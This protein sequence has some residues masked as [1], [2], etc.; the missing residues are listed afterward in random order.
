MKVMLG[1]FQTTFACFRFSTDTLHLDLVQIFKQLWF[2][3]QLQWTVLRNRHIPCGIT[4]QTT[5]S[6]RVHSQTKAAFCSKLKGRTAERNIL[7]T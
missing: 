3:D 6:T 7:L 1:F 5:L 2:N 4:T